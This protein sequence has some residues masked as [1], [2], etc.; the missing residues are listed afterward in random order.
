M[1]VAM[2]VSAFLLAAM[3]L[4]L[5]VGLRSIPLA[6]FW[7][8]MA[9]Y[10]PTNPA[11]VTVAQ[12]RLPRMLGG[13]VAGAALGLA[14]TVM[15]S[16]TRNP[17]ADPGIMG[18]NAG[19][20]LGLLL[21]S[22]LLGGIDGGG[23]VLLTFPGA[24]LASAAVFALGGGLRGDT[25]PIRL[26]L[27]GTA[28]NALFLSLVTGMVLLSQQSLNTMRFW[29]AGTL[30]LAES[31]PLLE[32]GLVTLAAGLLALALAPRLEALSLGVSLSRGLGAHPGRSQAGALLVVTLA[33]GAAVSVAGPVVFLGLMA[34]PMARL[35]VGHRLRAEI[36][37]SAAL[38]AGFLL[39]ADT[40]GRV[41]F[42][43]SE[44][45]VGVMIALLGAPIFIA[46]AR[47]MRPGAET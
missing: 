45:R 20:A 26:T 32:L 7:A 30:N 4:S 16:V 2:G 12:I 44:V 3:A 10:D 8:M 14:G 29:I 6:E 43:P 31:R 38:G 19:A 24:A 41:I 1:R 36:C 27:A 46:I 17:L 33:A 22:L 15:Q 21:G 25:G 39:L 9:H 18:V 37:V 13:L 5:G 11:H 23:A 35:L 40:L 28:L 34:P 42:P 47:R